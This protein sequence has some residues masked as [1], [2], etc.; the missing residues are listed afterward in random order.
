MR[1][2]G[3]DPGYD[4]LGIAI[5]SAGIPK[6]IVEFSTCIETNKDDAFVKRLL[7]L[8]NE[9]KH[10][11]ET[12]KPEV[13]ALELLFLTK[14]QKTAMR[15]AEVRGALLY[16]ISS[17]SIP[18]AEYTPLQIKQATTGNGKSG[19]TEVAK[20]L[21]LIATL[22]EKYRLDDEA[23]AIATALTHLAYSRYPHA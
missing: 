16:L 10:I 18:V 7:V 14:N 11:L 8:T 12:K 9:V 5:V 22:P 2:L 23:D 21:P 6:P 13:C 19:K 4:R 17:F 15:V 3:I 20:M 1:V